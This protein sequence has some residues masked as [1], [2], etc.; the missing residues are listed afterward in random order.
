MNMAKSDR[1]YKIDALG[2]VS[3][4]PTAFTGKGTLKAVLTGKVH[5]RVLDKLNEL[6]LP[7]QAHK[8]ANGAARD[9]R[10]ELLLALLKAT[11]AANVSFQERIFD[12]ISNPEEDVISISIN[13][14]G[15]ITLLFG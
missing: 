6:P 2:T 8:D 4:P 15:D 12:D 11:P 13:E 1:G 7:D 14:A 10:Q 9:L 5:P 3:L